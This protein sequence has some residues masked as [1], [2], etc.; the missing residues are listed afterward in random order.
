M[1]IENL[2]LSELKQLLYAVN[3]DIKISKRTKYDYA[4]IKKEDSRTNKI[5]QYLLSKHGF[6]TSLQKKL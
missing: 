3:S 6:K 2:S 5:K 1:N 4:L